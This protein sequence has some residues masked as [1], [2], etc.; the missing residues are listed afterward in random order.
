MCNSWAKLNRIFI[1]TCLASDEFTLRA[2]EPRWMG[3]RSGEEPRSSPCTM[4]SA[5]TETLHTWAAFTLATV[6]HCQ[7]RLAGTA[8][9]WTQIRLELVP[10]RAADHWTSAHRVLPISAPAYS[11]VLPF[12]PTGCSPQEILVSVDSVALDVL[13]SHFF[14]LFLPLVRDGDYFEL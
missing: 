8:C 4:G 3:R 14:Y 12:L 9:E 1:F 13:F 7:A 10:W 11:L 2:W 6:Y 5:L